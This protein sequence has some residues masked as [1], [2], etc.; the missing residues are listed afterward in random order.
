MESSTFDDPDAEELAPLAGEGERQYP[1]P[2]ACHGRN[3]GRRYRFTACQLSAEPFRK[4]RF[5]HSRLLQSTYDS[6]H[7]VPKAGIAE[8][9]GCDDTGNDNCIE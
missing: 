7:D 4:D 5:R 2:V 6:N 1:R 3:C 9:S 8:K